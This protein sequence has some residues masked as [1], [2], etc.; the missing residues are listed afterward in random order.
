M[1][2]IEA[3]PSPRFRKIEP[4]QGLETEVEVR[5]DRS[6]DGSEG[7]G[8]PVLKSHIGERELDKVRVGANA[9]VRL[10]LFYEVWANS[11]GDPVRFLGAE[12]RDPGCDHHLFDLRWK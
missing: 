11:A 4:C 10:R 7:F 9:S 12:T 8:E 5:I 1:L 6:L 2:R 3:R